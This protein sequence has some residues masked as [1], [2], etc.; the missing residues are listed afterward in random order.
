MMM[1]ILITCLLVVLITCLSLMLSRVFEFWVVRYYSLG[2]LS[3]LR[4]LRNIKNTSFV[5][6]MSRSLG[7]PPLPS[8][9]V[10]DSGAFGGSRPVFIAI[11]VGDAA[12]NRSAENRSA[13]TPKAGQA[14]IQ[15]NTA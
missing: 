7:R 14:N 2:S 13:K 6:P 11:G 10:A 15:T 12:G 4:N 5:V 3:N 9:S 8:F 1:M